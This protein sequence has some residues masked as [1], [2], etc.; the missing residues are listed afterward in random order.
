MTGGTRLPTAAAGAG[1]GCFDFLGA[2]IRPLV[3]KIK[4]D[5]RQILPRGVVT[6]SFSTLI[7]LSLFDSNAMVCSMTVVVLRKDYIEFHSVQLVPLPYHV[8]PSQIHHRLSLL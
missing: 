1:G 8:F 5:R 4:F 7:V 6:S 2:Q 3:L